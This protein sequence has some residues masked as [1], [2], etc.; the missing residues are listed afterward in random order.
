[1]VASQEQKKNHTGQKR[2]KMMSCPV[3]KGAGVIRLSPVEASPW[4]KLPVGR[5]RHVVGFVE[6]RCWA[7]AGETRL[8]VV[9]HDARPHVSS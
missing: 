3:C 9:D 4:N 1:M 7:C 6:Q 5:L 2:P 8:P